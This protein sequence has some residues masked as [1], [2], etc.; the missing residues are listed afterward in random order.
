[1]EQ[2]TTVIQMEIFKIV[3]IAQGMGFIA[4]AFDFYVLQKDQREKMLGIK[5]ITHFFFFLHYLLLGAMSGSVVNI[6]G[7]ARIYVFKRRLFKKWAN[8]KIWLYFFILLFII[9]GLV[10]WDGY[11]T[12]LPVTGMV[13]GT[14]AFWLHQPKQIRFLIVFSTLPWIVYNILVNSY[15]GIIGNVLIL[16]STGLGIYRF[17]KPKVYKSA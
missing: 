12:L 6:V 8:N 11:I 3:I 10:T 5:M 7:A 13:I 4:L 15:P 16:I 2:V 17:D 14:I 9:V 1:V